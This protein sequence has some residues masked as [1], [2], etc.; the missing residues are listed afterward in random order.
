MPFDRATGLRQGFSTLLTITTSVNFPV[1]LYFE[2]AQAR[3]GNR[4]LDIPTLHSTALILITQGAGQ[5]YVPAF[6]HNDRIKETI[7]SLPPLLRTRVRPIDSSG[8]LL[9]RV[10]GFVEPL[11]DQIREMDEMS[12]EAV[13]VRASISF[14]YQI[15]LGAKYGAGVTGAWVQHLTH[16]LHRIQFDA[17]KGE[18][19]ARMAVLANLI[20]SYKPFVSTRVGLTGYRGDP[21]IRGKLFEILDSTE[22]ADV[23]E[24]SGYLGLVRRPIVALRRLRRSVAAVVTRRDFRAVAKAAEA[25]AGLT[26]MTIPAEPLISIANEFDKGRQF[27]PPVFDLTPFRQDIYN[28]TLTEFDRKCKPRPGTLYQIHIH[29]PGICGN[30]SASDHSRQEPYDSRNHHQALLS[31]HTTAKAAVES[32]LRPSRN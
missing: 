20:V 13:F 10:L 4:L 17:F 21:E 28:A 25:I 12:P 14:L 3:L 29:Q 9:R 7:E 2:E 26:G 24:K 1:I 27:S 30:I 31:C 19:R 23:V 11:R 18:A 5:I 15:G 8:R 32:F 6:E 22:F 16:D